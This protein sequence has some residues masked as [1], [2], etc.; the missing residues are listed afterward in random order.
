MVWV[1]GACLGLVWCL[2]V[3]VAH[4]RHHGVIPEDLLAALSL[5]AERQG[6][7]PVA[8]GFCELPVVVLVALLQSGGSEPLVGVAERAI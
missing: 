8:T 3:V 2:S 1:S 5:T 7:A 4:Q 6:D